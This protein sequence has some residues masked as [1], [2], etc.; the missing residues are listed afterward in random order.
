MLARLNG[1]GTQNERH[2]PANP[3]ARRQ[4]VARYRQFSDRLAVRSLAFQV[5]LQRGDSFGKL[6]RCLSCLG[7]PCNVRSEVLIPPA[8]ER[9]GLTYFGLAWFHGVG[10]LNLP[11]VKT[12]ATHMPFCSTKDENSQALVYAGSRQGDPTY[13]TQRSLKLLCPGPFCPST[14]AC[15][16]RSLELKSA[17]DDRSDERTPSSI[18]RRPRSE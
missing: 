4:Q 6:C 11:S 7:H 2:D 5:V 1:L 13:R 9:A 16:E 12:L 14:L 17:A 10:S 3:F 15:S 8:Y 18:V